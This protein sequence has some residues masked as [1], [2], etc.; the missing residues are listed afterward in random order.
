NEPAGNPAMSTEILPWRKQRGPAVTGSPGY[1]S[2]RPR[3]EPIT[4]A[5][6]PAIAGYDS[7]SFAV[8]QHR[9]YSGKEG[10]SVAG[11]KERQRRLAPER[12]QRQQARRSHPTQRWRG[13]GTTVG[14][15]LPAL[16]RVGGGAAA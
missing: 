11:K 13:D 9:S 14:A 2:A 16:A 8:Q 1:R 7:R 5:P 15:R 10:D 6:V 3:D 12:Y 4:A